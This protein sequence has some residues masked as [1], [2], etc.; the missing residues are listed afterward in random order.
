MEIISELMTVAEI[1]ETH[2]DVAALFSDDEA[3]E[4]TVM[5]H[6]IVIMTVP[7]NNSDG[8]YLENFYH[9]YLH[10]ARH[11]CV[12]IETGHIMSVDELLEEA[13]PDYVEAVT[14]IYGHL[15]ESDEPEKPSGPTVH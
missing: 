2:P 13:L 3:S 4:I 15:Y 12:A 1:H 10:H 8:P 7:V 14:A 11:A 6:P 9:P 5:F